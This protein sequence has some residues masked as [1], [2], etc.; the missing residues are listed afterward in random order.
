MNIRY[1]NVCLESL[2]YCLPEEIVSSSEIESRLAPLYRH[3]KLP[4][5]RLEL[6]TGIRERRF[7]PAGEL[8]STRSVQSAEHALRAS[9]IDR[10]H[11][12]MLI[13]GSVCRDF[14]EPA[15]ACRVHHLLG[16]ASD[17]IAYD[18]SN[19]CLGM[20]SGALQI[21]NAIELGQIR[22]GLVVGT[23]NGRSLVETTIE[24][25]N[26]RAQASDPTLT[27]QSVKSAI[28]SLTIGSGSAAMLLVDRRL[29]LTGNQLEAAAIRANTRFHDLCHS[30]R[31]EAAGSGM[32]PLMET[33]SER[34]MHE[35]VG[36]GVDAFKAFLD[37]TGWSS[38]DLQQTFCHQVGAGHRKLLL[39]SFGVD[40]QYDFATFPW[41]GNTG[42]VALPTA[43]AIGAE[44]GVIGASEAG[45]R[46]G[47]FGIG[48]GIQCLMLGVDWHRSLVAGGEATQAPLPEVASVLA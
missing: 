7:W 33:D 29:S 26:R 17:C 19:A 13:H 48:S 37:A 39:E 23:E 34:L 44:Q 25:L 36:V 11:V 2:G 14:L 20:L 27:R 30:D 22:A 3:L 15:T 6:M 42:A 21:A 16:L 31:D 45:A 47:L 10:R 8:P 5:G 41:L 32:Q 1:Q 46:I 35:G 4:E 28:A 43:L 40:P 12:G 24:M 9:G 38:D 18:V